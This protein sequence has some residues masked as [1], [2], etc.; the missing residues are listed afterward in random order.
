M[1]GAGRATAYTEKPDVEETFHSLGITDRFDGSRAAGCS[2]SAWLFGGPPRC[3][4]G[5]F[6]VVLLACV[7]AAVLGVS[8]SSPLSAG[9]CGSRSLLSSCA[10]RSM[11]RAC[12]SGLCGATPVPPPCCR[13]A[14]ALASRMA[15]SHVC[16]SSSSARLT[17]HPTSRHV[18]ELLDHGDF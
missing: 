10:K 8:W 12:C 17:H 3:S 15:A 4:F 6:V 14:C 7:V 16:S 18:T 9:V 13:V 1:C 11:S 5:L 2:P